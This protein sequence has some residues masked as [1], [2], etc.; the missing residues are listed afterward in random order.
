ML[1]LSLFTA[2]ADCPS[3][4]SVSEWRSTLDSAASAFAGLDTDGLDAGV[5]RA[6]LG[7][8]CLDGAIAPEDAV[9]FHLLHGL[10][11]YTRGAREDARASFAAARAVDPAARLG[12]DLV[13]EGHEVHE[14]VER[15]TAG[16]ATE[17]VERPETGR[18]L[19]DGRESL[20]RPVERPTLAQWVTADGTR[21]DWL[22][23]DEALFGYPVAAAPV[24]VPVPTVV[25]DPVQPVPVPV[26]VPGPVPEPDPG[27]RKRFSAGRALLLVTST[28]AL[29]TAGGLYAMGADRAKRIEGP[30]DP[31]VTYP[32]LVAL[33]T[34]ANRFVIASGIVGGVGAVGLIGVVVVR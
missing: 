21:G 24:P 18:L 1:I 27:K 31:E 25:P 2:L 13:P 5:E 19:F 14:V 11:L 17:T 28:A 34:D 22:D 12:F 33:Q 26:P 7:L 3:P 30:H 10:A 23:V 6:Q 29:A 15:A 8:A 9:R 32:D 16:S 4:A 20:A